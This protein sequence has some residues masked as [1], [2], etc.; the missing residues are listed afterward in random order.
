MPGSQRRTRRRASKKLR[1]AARWV[2]EC[3]EIARRELSGER[4]GLHQDDFEECKEC[5]QGTECL[6]CGSTGQVRRQDPREVGKDGRLPEELE[7]TRGFV[8]AWGGI[9]EHGVQGFMLLTGVEAFHPVFVEAL[10]VFGG[11]L[12]RLEHE[13]DV[14]RAQKRSEK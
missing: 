8:E 5:T 7:L 14:E 6:A 1:A 13:A 10:A 11:E 9:Q 4:F 3:R 2:H 12:S